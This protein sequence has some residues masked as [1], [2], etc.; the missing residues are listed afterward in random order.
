MSSELRDAYN[1]I[2]AGIAV[3][4]RNAFE[5]RSDHSI[6]DVARQLSTIRRHRI[7]QV[8]T[9]K[10][11]LISV[12]RCVIDDALQCIIVNKTLRNA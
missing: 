7:S 11:F 9:F 4:L 2:R 3:S 1:A 12:S 8:V 5:T 10:Y 6:A